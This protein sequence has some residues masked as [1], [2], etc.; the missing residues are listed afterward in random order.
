MNFHDPFIPRSLT[1][2]SSVKLKNQ[3]LMQETLE[4]IQKSYVTVRESVPRLLC[5]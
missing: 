2:T 5:Q 3:V 1:E 4:T